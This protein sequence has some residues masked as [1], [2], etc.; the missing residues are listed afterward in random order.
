MKKT[1]TKTAA[2]KSTP[3]KSVDDYMGR[4]PEDARTTLEKLRKSIKAA[5]PQAEEFLS[6]QIPT[7]RQN[8]AILLAFGAA[9]N[10][11]ALYVMSKAVMDA[12]KDELAPYDL[13]PT[14]IRFPINDALPATLV[15]KIIKA[16]IEETEKKA[17][18]GK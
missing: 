4:L 16:R 2:T 6:Y 14:A 12:L 8:G 11:C 10:H 9:K 15:K 7:Y 17:K 1:T 13:A 5:I 3:L 18:K